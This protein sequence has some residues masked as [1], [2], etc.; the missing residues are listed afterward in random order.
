MVVSGKKS[1]D[2][3]LIF[4]KRSNQRKKKIRNRKNDQWDI[5]LTL[6]IDKKIDYDYDDWIYGYASTSN[7][8]TDI[9]F[10]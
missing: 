10:S 5:K 6:S 7:I 2:K 1:S 8:N 4:Y 9:A 3:E